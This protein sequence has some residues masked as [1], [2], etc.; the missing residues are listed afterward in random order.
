MSEDVALHPVE[1]DL[2]CTFAEVQP[3]FP[4]TIPDTGLSEPER[5][6]MFRAAREQLARRGL[7]DE[8]GP[9]G[10]ADEFAHLL[11][12]GDG[13][14]DLVVAEEK[15]TVAAV[16]LH[17]RG[18]ALIAV[19]RAADP[20]GTVVLRQ[21]TLDRAVDELCA[22]VPRLDPASATPFTLP[23]KALQAAFEALLADLPT[24]DGVRPRKLPPRVVE[25]ILAVHGV[26]DRVS[27]RMVQYLQPV[28]G[29]GQAG[30]ARRSGPG[31]DWHR[32]GDETRW[33]DTGNGRYQLGG[34]EDWTSVNPLSGAEIRAA[35][36]KLAA[37][38][39]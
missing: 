32:C 26:D 38:L 37:A 7:A 6:V 10:Q 24:E 18:D 30:V 15:T 33:L 4:L 9:L 29:N 19:Q 1:V 20:S 17:Y 11:R 8:D 39:R 12:F 28:L 35:L 21:A 3:P 14:L 31:D 13:V 25:E 34:D 23:R 27:R 36:R 5:A 22:I 2:L 16:V